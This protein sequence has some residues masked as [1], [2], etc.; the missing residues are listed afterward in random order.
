MELAE[1][2][3]E[4][5]GRTFIIKEDLPGIVYDERGKCTFDFLQDTLE[6]CKKIALDRFLVP[7][8]HWED[9]STNEN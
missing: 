5:K 8:Y 9:H 1:Y 2:K 3:A 4:R 6:I 7:I